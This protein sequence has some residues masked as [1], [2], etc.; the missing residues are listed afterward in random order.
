MDILG[1]EGG[2]T[3]TT[4]ARVTRDG[5]VLARGEAGPGNTLLLTDAALRDLLRGIARAA[6]K[7]VAA[8]GGAFAGCAQAAEQQRV[9]MA[10]R[11]AW[12]AVQTVRVMEDT[13]SILAA[14]FGDGPGHCRHRG[15]GLECG[16]AGFAG[17]ADR[18]GGRLGSSL[19]GS[20]QRLRHRA[21][22]H[23]GCLRALR[24]G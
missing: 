24:C 4:W 20:R 8:I 17:R 1:I 9:E 22:R 18:E 23:G 13:R 11:A 16:G 2:G 12:P 3:K 10:L 14:A 5:R 7:D 15:H 6:G 19:C 21:A